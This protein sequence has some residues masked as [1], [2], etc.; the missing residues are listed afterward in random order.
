MRVIRKAGCLT[1]SVRPHHTRGTSGLCVHSSYR[2]WVTTGVSDLQHACVHARLG[3]SASGPAAGRSS[4]PA[5]HRD[6]RT[7]QGRSGFV[8]APS[9]C[10][11]GKAAPRPRA[12]PSALRSPVRRRTL[13]HAL[14]TVPRPRATLCSQLP[15]PTAHARPRLEN[16]GAHGPGSPSSRNRTVPPRAAPFRWSR[17]PTSKQRRGGLRGSGSAGG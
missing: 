5:S 3:V 16:R 2:S 14:R 4:R 6:R 12:R 9:V 17:S 8:L 1:V 7:G 15:A 13:G 10:C 11:P